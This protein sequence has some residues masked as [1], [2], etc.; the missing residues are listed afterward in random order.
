MS[1]TS[2]GPGWWLASDGKWY[3]PELWTGPPLPG[4]RLPQSAPTTYPGRL[5][6]WGHSLPAGRSRCRRVPGPAPDPSGIPRDTSA[7]TPQPY[8]QDPPY[9]APVKRNNGLAI[10]SLVCACAGFLFIVP[11]VLAVI[12]GFIARSQSPPVGRDAGR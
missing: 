1:D 12:F 8:G 9:G 11:A 10:A 3:P 7:S 2:Q 6:G 4:P 5:P